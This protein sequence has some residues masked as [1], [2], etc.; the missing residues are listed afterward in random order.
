M[1]GHSRAHRTISMI[2]VFVCLW[3]SALQQVHTGGA[4][5]ICTSTARL[6]SHLLCYMQTC[7]FQ[8]RKRR[9]RNFSSCSAVNLLSPSHRLQ[10]V[11]ELGLHHGDLVDD[12]VATG[13]PVLQHPGPLSQLDALLQGGRARTNT[14]RKVVH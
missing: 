4:G 5:L 11:K 14:W 2:S 8:F 7:V 3:G 10:L 6:P 1:S 13:S 12:E 9:S